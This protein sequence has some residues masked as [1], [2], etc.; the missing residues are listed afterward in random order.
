[1]PSPEL[2][3]SKTNAYCSPYSAWSGPSWAGSLNSRTVV[4]EL[5]TQPLPAL[6]GPSPSTTGVS[7]SALATTRQGSMVVEVVDEVEVVLEVE[8]VLVVEVVEVVL[9]VLEV[10]VVDVDDVVDV[11]VL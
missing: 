6:R 7:K 2:P 4:S 11:V 5:N 9:E 8:E 10:L 1:M 3:E